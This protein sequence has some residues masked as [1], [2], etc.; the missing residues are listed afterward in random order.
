MTTVVATAVEDAVDEL[1]PLVGT[2]AAC[3][4]VG[5][6]RASYYRARPVEPPAEGH[7]VG[8]PND[9]VAPA[10]TGS[11]GSPRAR[12]VQPRALSEGERA[13][14]LQ[15]LHSQRF[16]DTAPASVYATLLDEGTYLC[17][18]STMY[19]LLREH[20]ET[21]DRRR[22]ATHPARVKPELVADAPNRV[23]SWDFKC[24]RRHLKSYADLGTMP[25]VLVGVGLT[26]RVGVRGSA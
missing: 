6:P 20:G 23:W 5:L 19:R 1:V 2:R 13:R 24:R 22:H 7:D 8:S 14:V 17:S 11:T 10:A 21:G 4:A 9:A 18:E 12:R 26:S 15:V 3:E 25:M 16:A